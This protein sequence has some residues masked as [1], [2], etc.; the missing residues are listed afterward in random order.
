MNALRITLNSQQMRLKGPSQQK[1]A[2]VRMTVGQTASWNM[3]EKMKSLSLDPRK[4]TIIH[5]LQGACR[6]S[7]EGALAGRLRY[8][9]KQ[10]VHS[11]S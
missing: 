5:A 10:N 2:C 7:E 8:R 3:G 9:Q 6:E 4:Q 11:R 1:G